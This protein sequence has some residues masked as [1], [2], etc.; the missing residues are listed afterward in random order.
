MYRISVFLTF[1]ACLALV[2]FAGCQQIDRQQVKKVEAE[3]TEGPPPASA[4]PGDLAEIEKEAKEQEARQAYKE[5]MLARRANDLERAGEQF[6]RALELD[7][8]YTE[9]AQA[10]A[11][12][13]IAL[14]EAAPAGA[15][16]VALRVKKVEAQIQLIRHEVAA[17]ISQGEVFFQQG[18]FED[19]VSSL[20]EAL[21]LIKWASELYLLD[22]TEERDRAQALL[23]S[24]RIQRDVFVRAREAEQRKAAEQ[25]L[26]EELRKQADYRRRMA[27]ELLALARQSLERKD[28]VEALSFTRRALL[29]DPANSEAMRLEKIIVRE[30]IN[31]ERERIRLRTDM[32]WRNSFMKMEEAALP[33]AGIMNYPDREWWRNMTVLRCERSK[34]EQNV[35]ERTP[36]QENI[37]KKLEQVTV[38]LLRIESQK[39]PD[40]M[41]TIMKQFGNIV[42]IVIHPDA[43]VELGDKKIDIDRPVETNL[44]TAIEIALERIPDDTGEYTY[45]IRDEAILITKKGAEETKRLII[46][47]VQ[48]LLR[49]VVPFRPP[50]IEISREDLFEETGG[51]FGDV[52]EE[53]R[54]YFGTEDR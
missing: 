14:G 19:A 54:D 29:K 9:A 43:L 7:P 28:F 30:R 13:K 47:P 31:F 17:T 27:E 20:E 21:G 51:E 46:Y 8:S 22:F 2:V 6:E 10:L 18:K 49:Q 36:E 3:V 33:V 15:P 41:K 32:A 37:E 24:A 5:G 44:R 25:A 34:R 38:R 42:P 48:D 23:E 45:V 35:F 12:V 50:D 4:G 40:A 53:E 39:F 1:V 11:E 52:G 26:A 16:D